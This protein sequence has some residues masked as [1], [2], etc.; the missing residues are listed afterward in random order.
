MVAFVIKSNFLIPCRRFLINGG[1]EVAFYE[2]VTSSMFSVRIDFKY[3]VQ[4][5]S[6]LMFINDRG[7]LS[8]R[9]ESNLETATP[10]SENT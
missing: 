9:V 1:D 6:S 8:T 2:S 3:P 7:K 10:L 4:I 5:K